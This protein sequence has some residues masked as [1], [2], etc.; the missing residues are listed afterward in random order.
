ML[1]RVVVL[2]FDGEV[3]KVE[4][5]LIRYLF[6]RTHCGLFVD[7]FA[8]WVTVLYIGRKI[9]MNSLR[10]RLQTTQSRSLVVPFNYTNAHE[11]SIT[12][13][14]MIGFT[15]IW[16]YGQTSMWASVIGNVAIRTPVA[17][18]LNMP[19]P[20]ILYFASTIAI[21]IDLVSYQWRWRQSKEER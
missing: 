1:S 10:R 4:N 14:F 19:Q 9:S 15:S 2:D 6:L 21:S 17:L 8:K 13:S 16:S 11:S 20:L 18:A 7:P 12:N 5:P 3:M